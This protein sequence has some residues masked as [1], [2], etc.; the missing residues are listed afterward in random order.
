MHQPRCLFMEECRHSLVVHVVRWNGREYTESFLVGNTSGV[1]SETAKPVPPV[2]TIKLTGS[3]ESAHSMSCRWIRA[4]ESG[5][6]LVSVMFQ[7]S[8]PSCSKTERSAFPAASVVGS[9][10][11]VVDTTRIAALSVSLMTTR[12]LSI[13]QNGVYYI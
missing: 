4:T 1:W 6:I 5:T 11:A 2:V 10:A 8:A 7:R 12:F 9:W 13:E 3:A